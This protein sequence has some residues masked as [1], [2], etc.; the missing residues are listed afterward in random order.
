MA[1]HW[2]PEMDSALREEFEK[3]SNLELIG[4]VVGVAPNTARRRASALGLQ[5]PK[6]TPKPFKNSDGRT[7]SEQKFAELLAN[8][9]SVAEAG[10]QAGYASGNAVMQRIRAKLGWQAV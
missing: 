3:G 2:V 9:A 1:I 10:D 5:R 4:A 6:R 8:G 7:A